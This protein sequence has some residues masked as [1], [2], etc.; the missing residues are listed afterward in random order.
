MQHYQYK[1]SIHI[2]SI[3]LPLT[4]NIAIVTKMTVP[5]IARIMITNGNNFNKW[6]QESK[7]GPA[8]TQQH[9]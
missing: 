7:I 3:R 4:I 6:C 8:A 1:Q 5:P 9:D 2:V